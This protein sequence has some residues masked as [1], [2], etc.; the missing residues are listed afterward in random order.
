MKLLIGGPT[1]ASLGR[2]RYTLNAYQRSTVTHDRGQRLKVEGHYR[3]E[4]SMPVHNGALNRSDMPV[5]ID[6]VLM[7][8]N[9]VWVR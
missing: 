3:I 4:K 7:E 5:A 8:C 9:S 6:L 2:P 1:V